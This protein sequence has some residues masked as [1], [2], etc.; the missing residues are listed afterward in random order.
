MSNVRRNPHRT[1]WNRLGLGWKL[2]ISFASVLVLTGILGFWATH[3]LS[4]AME[5]AAQSSGQSP[6]T[7]ATDSSAASSA[8][9]QASRDV[10]YATLAVVVLGVILAVGVIRSLVRSLRQCHT[11]IEALAQGDFDQQL[12]VDRNDEVGQ[13]ATALNSCIAAHRPVVEKGQQAIDNLTNLPTP[14]VAIDKEY[15]IT[16]INPAGAT[17]VGLT[18]EQ[19]RGKK[20]YD[21]FKT[22]HCRTPQCRLHQAMQNDGTFSGETVAHLPSG[23]LPIAYTGTPIKDAHDQIVGALEFVVDISETKKAMAEAQK[24][25]DNLDNLPTPI[26]TIDTDFNVTSMNPAGAGAVGLTP[27]EC[28]GRKCYDLFKTPHCQTA[29]CRCGQAMKN[30]GTFTGET[31]VDPEGKNLPIMY[32]GSPIKDADGKII[33]A[34]EYVVDIATVQQTELVQGA[35]RKAQ[36]IAAYQETEVEKVAATLRA[37]AEGDLTVDYHAAESDEDTAEVCRSFTAVAEATNATIHN[38]STMIGQI[39]ES[40]NQFAEGSRVIAESSQTLAAGAQNQSSSVEEMSASIEE[41]TRSIEAVKGNAN[42]ANGVA[43]QTT[44]LAERGGT[45]VKE[46]I[47]A[48]ELIRNSSTQI[49][50]IIQVISEIA[51]QTNLLALNAAI[52]AARAGEHGM[53]FAVVADEVRKLAERSNQA[54]GEISSLIKESTQRVEEGFHR[55][56]ETGK[57]L[58]EIIEGAEATAAKIAEIATATVQQAANATE[59]A[60]AIQSVADVTEQAAAG[61]EEMASSSEE[62]GAQASTLRD[63]VSRFKI[64]SSSTKGHFAGS[65]T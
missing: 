31:I 44:Q 21:L 11:V 45:A 7:N 34:L 6:A 25:V 32:T 51:S 60:T 61:S 14:V 35:Q 8:W 48:M 64:D 9:Q 63:V 65:T 36:K 41:L 43:Q 55:S 28:V 12:A 26:M 38:L 29:E 49:G 30:N 54:A 20:C 5:F 52:E 1:G 53:G 59:V 56:E 27:Q 57:S 50:E 46:S 47:S 4:G 2:G 22:P 24:A 3:H 15:N 13:I 58:K 40:A 37:V 19:C 42:D 17:A 39:T 33:G 10:R 23:E 16:F 18:S 62:L